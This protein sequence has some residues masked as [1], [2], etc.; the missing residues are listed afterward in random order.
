MA[1]TWAGPGLFPYDI[2]IDI[3][4]VREILNHQRFLEMRLNQLEST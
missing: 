2:S 3:S 4:E 1:P